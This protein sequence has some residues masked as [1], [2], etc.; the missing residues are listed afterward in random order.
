[1]SEATATRAVLREFPQCTDITCTS[2]KDESNKRGVR[3]QNVCGYVV[4]EQAYL[5]HSAWRKTSTIF[6][7]AYKAYT[8]AGNLVCQQRK[9][10]FKGA[11]DRDQLLRV[12]VQLCATPRSLRLQ[13]V[14]L[15][16]GLHRC[17]QV[18]IGCPLEDRLRAFSWIQIMSRIEEICNVLVFY[19]RSWRHMESFFGLQPMECEPRSTT[20]SITRRGTMTMRFTWNGAPWSSSQPFHAV[21]LAMADFVRAMI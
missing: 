6:G 21:T 3:L 15:S 9:I 8:L 7:T 20:V 11:C 5:D 16:V 18:N 4:T 13:L 1:M 14:V 10:H 19:V 2:G 17:L 12:L